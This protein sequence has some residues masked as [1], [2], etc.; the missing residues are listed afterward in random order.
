MAIADAPQHSHSVGKDADTFFTRLMDSA[1]YLASSE[2]A[3]AGWLAYVLPAPSAAQGLSLSDALGQLPGSFIFSAVAPVLN[4]ARAVATFISTVQLIFSRSPATRGMLWLRDADAPT[5]ENTAL[6][7][8]DDQG[9]YVANGLQAPVFETLALNVAGGMTLTLSDE[10]LLLNTPAKI[11][12]SGATAPSTNQASQ[13]ACGTLAFTGANRGCIQFD[14]HLQRQFLHDT[15]DW[16]FQFQVPHDDPVRTALGAWL[17]LALGH[18][19]AA[20]DLLGFHVSYD[21]SDPLNAKAAT[22]NR[23]VLVFTGLNQDLSQTRLHSCYSTPYGQL[24][25]LQPVPGPLDREPLA[26]RLLFNAGSPDEKGNHDYQLAPE[27]DFV[28]NLE[29]AVDGAVCD[30]MCGLQG[31]EFIAFQPAVQGGY[32]GDRLRFVA[33]CPAYAPHYPF[34]QVSPVEAPVPVQKPLLD[35][36]YTTSW[37]TLVRAPGASGVPAYIAQPKGAPL[38]GRDTLIHATVRDT[39]FGPLAPAQGLDANVFPLVPYAGF[40]PGN[41]ITSFTARLAADF[42]RQVVSPTRRKSIGS[43]PAATRAHALGLTGT[44]DGAAYQATTPSGLLASVNPDGSWSRLLL[45]QNLAPTLAQ[46][47]FANPDE[48]LQQAFQT[49]DLFLVVANAQHLGAFGDAT[50]TTAAFQ[51]RMNVGDWVFEADVGQANRYDDYASIMIVKGRHG[52]LWDPQAPQGS[53]VA[54]PQLWTQRD[55][56]AAPSNLGPNAQVGAPNPDELPTLSYWLQRYFQDALEQAEPEYFE[57]F[58]AIARNPGWTGILFLRMKIANIPADLAGIVAGVR[59]PERFNAHHFGIEISQVANDPSATGIELATSSSLFGLIYYVDPDFTATPAGTAPQPIAPASG[60]DYA[61]SV[62]TLKALFENTAVQRFQS[63]AQLTLG[64]LFG[65]PVSKMGDGGNPF[66][67]LVLRGSYQNN[68]GR[69][70]YNLG[71]TATSTFYVANNLFNK[72]EVNSAQMSTRQAGAGADTLS[73]FALSG[74]LDFAVVQS[75]DQ[76][77]FDL[78]S[79]G[80]DPGAD[81]LRRGLAF[82]NLGVLMKA[83]QA[84]PSAPTFGFSADEI[85]FDIGTST[86]RPDSLFINFALTLQGLVQGTAA[87]TPQM[88]G[89]ADV[90]SDATLNSV[91]GQPWFG[92]CFELDM[93]SPGN[94]AGSVGLTSR[95]LTAWCPD[96]SSA[97]RYRANLGLQL[98]GTGGGANLISLQNVL[99]LSIGQMKLTYDRD[100]QSFL[101]MLT[102]IAIKFMGLLK[103]PP[104]G[105]TLFYLFGNPQRDG[106][107]S[108]LG[109]YAMYR[110]N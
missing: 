68:D 88:A 40:V 15:W 74:F 29:G 41:G 50:G 13:V 100:Q 46:M 6:M 53:L 26:A 75:T 52:A 39:L 101:L 64:K 16:G 17:P 99:R 58:N 106:K 47:S 21:P 35:T 37:A 94:L 95:L 5:L 89:Y 1:L 12:F 96:S 90:I 78:F 87:A 9:S 38:Y 108:G 55:V 23:S 73:W 91:S 92:L 54:N 59:A 24:L 49:S 81:Q 93:G 31:T 71:T 80:S 86:P 28:L 2:P 42:E 34:A 44:A 30:L 76:Q 8:L 107:A 7:G 70:T 32:A 61:F 72:I 103:I 79:F 36:T 66:A 10:T 69:G 97:G 51:N 3:D 84:S 83:T 85:R 4:D 110:K 82:S 27:G 33:R 19:P 63:Y 48:L 98:P 62:L 65:M 109:W 18:L 77:G 11:F 60:A 45:A 14:F 20:S 22:A 105:S 67:T 104:S 25:G 43:R 102:D 56:F 57:K